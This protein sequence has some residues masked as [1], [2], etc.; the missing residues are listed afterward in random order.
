METQRLYLR[1]LTEHDW[2]LMMAWR[3]NPLV[4]EEGCYTQKAPLE[5]SEHV[6]WKR[7]R[8]RWWQFFII[9]L[10]SDNLPER[11]VGVINFGQLDNWNVECNY[12]LGEVSLWGQGIA[13]EALSQ[14]ISWLR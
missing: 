10:S 3:S 8:G 13:T 4:F 9:M 5:W 11:P 2:P 7:S 14:A 1:D 12:Y 6:T